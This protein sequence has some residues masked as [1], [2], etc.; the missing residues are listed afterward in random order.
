MS[1][2]F[3]HSN[4]ADVGCLAHCGDTH[5]PTWNARRVFCIDDIRVWSRWKFTITPAWL[6]PKPGLPAQL[7]DEAWTPGIYLYLSTCIFCTCLIN[8]ERLI[9]HQKQSVSIH[10][11]ASL[12]ISIPQS[13]VPPKKALT[14][15]S[16][17]LNDGKSNTSFSLRCVGIWLR[18]N[19]SLIVMSCK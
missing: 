5:G 13:L 7:F 18:Q 6:H 2:P 9:G 3:F 15:R 19:L 8:C 14:K 17:R 4:S 11:F 1:F 10:F 12:H 16:V